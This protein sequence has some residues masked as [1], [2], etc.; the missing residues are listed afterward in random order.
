MIEI[1]FVLIFYLLTRIMI[2]LAAQELDRTK[3]QFSFERGQKLTRGLLW[4]HLDRFL[5]PSLP[6]VDRIF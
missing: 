6:A 5:P 2:A 4:S 3:H 1:D